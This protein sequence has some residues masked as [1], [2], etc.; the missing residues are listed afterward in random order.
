MGRD[1]EWVCRW[2]GMWEGGKEEGWVVRKMTVVSAFHC[3]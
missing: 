2:V 3:R 1:H